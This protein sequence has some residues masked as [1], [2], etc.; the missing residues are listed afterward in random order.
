[1]ILGYSVY[2]LLWL[3]LIYAF[4]G[5]CMEVAWCGIGEGYFSNR[6]F[7]NGPVCPI[8][9]FGAVAVILCLT[10]IENTVLLFF[11]S[12][13]ITSVLELITGFALEKIYHTRWWDYSDLPFNIGGY[14]CLKYSIYWGFACI[15]LMKGLHPFVYG[16]VRAC[17]K[18]LGV[19]LVLFLLTVF[20]ADVVITLVTINKL[21]KRVKVMNE[22]AEKI[23]SVSDDIG[24]H[25]Y[26]GV[27]AAVNIA[28]ERKEKREAEIAELKEKYAKL[29]EERS[30]FQKRIIKAFPK[31]KSRK[32]GEHFEKI[33]D[34]IKKR[35][36]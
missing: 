8:Y 30:I 31:M 34:K 3:F 32:Y 20:I 26:D 4:L 15:G 6:G 19:V 29:S 18:I 12:M 16:I 21:T 25:I 14:I 1:M 28:E 17:P 36:K 24:E 5:W 22:I 13:G 23:H 2:E 35:S 33:R 7:L 27:T 9:G 10:P 11:A